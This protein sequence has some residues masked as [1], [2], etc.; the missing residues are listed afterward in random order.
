MAVGLVAAASWLTAAW[1]FSARSSAAVLSAKRLA[2]SCAFTTG[3][4]TWLGLSDLFAAGAA[5]AATAGTATGVG[6][7]AET[8]TS[9][10]VFGAGAAWR[11]VTGEASILR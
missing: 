1:A 7:G 2:A 8:A 6:A 3:S 11:A 9:V 4:T 5:T 10:A